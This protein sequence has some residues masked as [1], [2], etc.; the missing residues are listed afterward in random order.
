MIERQRLASAGEQIRGALA[1][2]LDL[3]LEHVGVK[4]TRGKRMG[5]VGRGKRAPRWRLLRAPMG[6]ARWVGTAR[7]GRTCIS[8][9]ARGL[10]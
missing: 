5:F 9:A 8:T 6:A 1:G 4:A 10:L 3:P 2:T 7:S